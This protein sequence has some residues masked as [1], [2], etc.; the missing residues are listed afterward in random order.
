[1]KQTQ[2]WVND[3]NPKGKI[4]GRLEMFSG[5]YETMIQANELRIGNWYDF[6]N[7]MAGGEHSPQQ[8]TTYDEFLSFENYSRP[9]PLTT[10]ILEK[11]GFNGNVLLLGKRGVCSK[12]WHLLAT[13][14]KDRVTV[15][16]AYDYDDC[17]YAAYD[18]EHD[19]NVKYLHQLQNLY[20]ALTGTEL[21]YT[22]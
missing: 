14:Y 19:T 20:F 8:L 13:N 22:P 21:T 2:M 18:F 10:E 9:I 4:I 3:I 17:A 1:M 5:K 11:C 15:N 16:L 7:P 12:E 6:A